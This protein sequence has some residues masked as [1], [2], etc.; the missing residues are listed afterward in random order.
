MRTLALWLENPIYWMIIPLALD[1]TPKIDTDFIIMDTVTSGRLLVP[2]YHIIHD[3]K[4]YIILAPTRQSSS[5]YLYLNATIFSRQLPTFAED[6]KISFK[7][8]LNLKNSIPNI[9]GGSKT[10]LLDPS[11]FNLTLA[12]RLE[13]I[14]NNIISLFLTKYSTQK[15]ERP[16][17][18]PISK[19]SISVPKVFTSTFIPTSALVSIIFTTTTSTPSAS[20]FDDTFPPLTNG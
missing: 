18:T 19:V 14:P 12:K 11:Q 2:N 10:L 16:I 3:K 6:F 20:K 8:Y 7:Q 15:V 9:I 5:Y 1:V 4:V 17:S 13:K